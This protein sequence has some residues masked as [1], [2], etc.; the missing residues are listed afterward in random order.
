MPVKLFGFDYSPEI[1]A[2][3]KKHKS[4]V[5]PTNEDGAATV[6]VGANFGAYLDLEGTVRTEAE[7]V[8]KYRNMALQPEVDRAI[9]EVVNEAIIFEDNTEPIQ[10]MMDSVPVND[11]V[12]RVFMEEFANV[13]KLLD[14]RNTGYDIFRRWYIDGRLYYHCVVNDTNLREG[15]KELRYIDPRKIRKIRETKKIKDPKSG[16]ELQY[17]VNEYYIYNEGG[18]NKSAQAVGTSKVTGIKI[19]DD[20]VVHIVSG[21]MDAENK[22]VLSYLHPAIKQLNQ[23]RSLEDA[24]MIYHLSRAPERRVFYIDVGNLPKMKAEQYVSEMMVKYKNK[25]AY[26][27]VTGEMRDERRF[28]TMLEDFWLPRREGGRGTQIDILQGGS[29]LSDLLENTQYFQ[30]NL[31]KALQV[32]T[33]RLKSDSVYD[34]G[35]ATQISRDEVTF[36]K[37]IDRVRSKFNKL[38]LEIMEKQLVLKGIT[39]YEEWNE[40]KRYIRFDYAK[41]TYHSELKESEIWNDR[42]MRL[43]DMDDFVGK[44]FSAEWIRRHILRQN[45]EE[46]MEIDAQIQEEMN[47]P[48]YHP[49][50]LQPEQEQIGQQETLRLPNPQEKK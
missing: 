46:M 8:S 33:S 12:K 49:E 21:L 18:F 34:V 10:L 42:I 15:V 11:N 7:L 48:Q 43:R 40:I 24:S 39:S 16:A 13:L 45:D 27:A 26:N 25:L 5:P 47:N 2:E 38:F 3:Q 22:M 28:M 32:P 1:E 6:A 23:L 17:T 29:Q 19:T 50:L 4:F 30:E 9:N 44:Y 36:A 14:F 41:D 37:F 20:A 35:R 31:Y